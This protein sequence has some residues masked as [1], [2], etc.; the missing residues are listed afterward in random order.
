VNV[1]VASRRELQRDEVRFQVLRLL[2]DNPELSV[3]EIA[4]KVGAS[5]GSVY[6]CLKALVDKGLVKLGNFAASKHKGR[7]A[8]ILTPHGLK[9]KAALTARFLSLRLEEYELLKRELELLKQEVEA[10]QESERASGD[11]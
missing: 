5:S 4:S 6:Y 2:E 10:A 7:Y 11:G 9:E 3:R 1:T 8:Y